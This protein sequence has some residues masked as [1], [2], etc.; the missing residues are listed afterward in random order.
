MTADDTGK[1]YRDLK[2]W[3]KAMDLTDAVYD[4]TRDFPVDERFALTSQ[5]RRSVTSNPLQHRGGLRPDVP[6]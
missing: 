5:I 4:L 3:Q 2:V 6:A 1:S